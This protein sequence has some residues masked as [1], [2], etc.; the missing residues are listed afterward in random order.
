MRCEKGI[1]S[2]GQL[3]FMAIGLVQGSVL[4]LTFV[5]RITKQDTWIVVLA[6]L[7]LTLF[8]IY[9][10]ISIMNRFPKKNIIEINNMVFGRIIGKFI[11]LIYLYHFFFIVLGN[12][13]FMGDFAEQNILAGTPF[14]VIVS[15]FA[16]ISAYAVRS[17]VEVIARCST[18]LVIISFVITLIMTSLLLKEINLSNFLPM[19][20]LSLKEF[21]QGSHITFSIPF[22]EIIVFFMIVPYINKTEKIKS[23]IFTGAIVSGIYILFISLRNVSVLGVVLFKSAT[24]AYREATIIDVGNTLTRLE[25]LVA[26]FFLLTIFTKIC[27]FYYSSVLGI[28]SFFSLKEYKPIV[29]PFGIIV[30]CLSI[31]VFKSPIEQLDFGANIFPVF[32]FPV[33]VI[34]PILTLIIAKIR[35]L[36]K[37]IV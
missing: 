30:V 37:K 23:S 28:A 36:P 27:L 25:V 13:R 22:S 17:G 31:V 11:S 18:I 20:Q 12:L 35:K 2:S 15:V 16:L 29:F 34:I 3:T 21:I 14:L 7:I 8:M 33:E 9:I 10:Y 5:Y 24:P 32:S 19:F 4:T 1:I 6:G 26:V